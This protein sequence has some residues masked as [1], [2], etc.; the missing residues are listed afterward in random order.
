MRVTVSQ[1]R[2]VLSHPTSVVR[3]EHSGGVVQLVNT[4]SNSQL[5]IDCPIVNGQ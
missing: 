2:L 4:R 1:T 5:Y 3:M